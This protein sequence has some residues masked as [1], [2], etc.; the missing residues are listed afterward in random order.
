MVQLVQ[1]LYRF[2]IVSSGI[3][4]VGYNGASGNAAV[5]LQLA[6]STNQ[7]VNAG[8]AANPSSGTTA[9]NLNM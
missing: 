2:F 8:P 9:M 1:P 3:A 4:S 7:T 5:K 6:G